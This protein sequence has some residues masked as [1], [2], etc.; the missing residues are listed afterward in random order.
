MKKIF[1][2][3]NLLALA[4]MVGCDGGSDE[5]VD[6]IPGDVKLSKN[7]IT[8]TDEMFRSCRY[9]EERI[10]VDGSGWEL[11]SIVIYGDD[12]E[13]ETVYGEIEGVG[14]TI[15]GFKGPWFEV[16]R[17]RGAVSVKLE[18]WESLK[19]DV[20][21]G[22]TLTFAVPRTDRTATLVVRQSPC[23]YPG[24][25]DDVIGLSS[26]ELDF[27]AA[28]G[29][30]TVTT[31]GETWSM[32]GLSVGQVHYGFACPGD[33]ERYE[34]VLKGEYDPGMGNGQSPVR[35]TGEWFDI[36]R[37]DRS[38]TVKLSPNEGP[39]RDMSL[40]LNLGDYYDY[41]KI[42]QAGRE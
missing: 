2:I 6:P 7:E 25:W 27:G 33:I 40:C 35:V 9:T 14:R 29:E 13:A 23:P 22:F 38:V 16:A 21:R 41:L 26:K 30:Q 18:A 39:A 5:P 4:G 17:D 8:T 24:D 3:L 10:V 12:A 1:A 15:A 11:A 34:G 42:R 20:W 28:G 37:D 36:T 32:V 19:T 31:E